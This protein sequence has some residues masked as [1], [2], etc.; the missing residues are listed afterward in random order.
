MLAASPVQVERHPL[1]LQRRAL[2]QMHR[3]VLLDVEERG[4]AC[5]PGCRERRRSLE[6]V[7][8]ES[9]WHVAPRAIQPRQ[10][11]QVE[12]QRGRGLGQIEGLYEVHEER[13]PFPQDSLARF[14]GHATRGAGPVVLLDDPAVEARIEA[15]VLEVGCLRHAG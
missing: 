1:P 12:M 11:Q 4:G 3:A 2:A 13:A 10:L 8:F 5:F 14:H 6:Q 15:S 7:R 9:I